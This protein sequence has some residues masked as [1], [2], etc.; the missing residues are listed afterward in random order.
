MT[1]SS[2]RSCWTDNNSLFENI[3]CY[4]LRCRCHRFLF[5]SNIECSN[6]NDFDC[7]FY[8]SLENDLICRGPLALTS[9]HRVDLF[10]IYNNL[11]QLCQNYFLLTNSIYS[12]SMFFTASMP[13]HIM[14]NSRVREAISWNLQYELLD[15]AYLL[16]RSLCSSDIWPR[17]SNLSNYAISSFHQIKSFVWPNTI[18]ESPLYPTKITF[19]RWTTSLYKNGQRY[20]L[21]THRLLFWK[22]IRICYW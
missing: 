3:I 22:N 20:V 4:L 19:K 6:I 14:F 13:S 12:P 8:C 18:S 2:S 1:A 21:I 10:P 7:V 15:G 16:F 5:L 17:E 11:R 9:K